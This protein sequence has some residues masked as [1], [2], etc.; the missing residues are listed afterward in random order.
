MRNEKAVVSAGKEEIKMQLVQIAYGTELYSEEIEL[1]ERILRIPLGLR[2]N[3]EDLAAEKN[4]LRFGLL[5]S[6]GKLAACLLVRIL[7]KGI[8]K[9]RQMAVREE[10]QGKGVGREL[11]GKVEKALLA[12]GFSSIE[13]HARK[14]AEGFYL[15][16]GYTMEGEPFE[17]VGIPHIKMVKKL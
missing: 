9:L 13:L 12:D 10:L 15:K 5:D 8:G 6:S 17:E 11:I 2:F 16:L 14:Y 3:A 7:Q 1:R 4:E